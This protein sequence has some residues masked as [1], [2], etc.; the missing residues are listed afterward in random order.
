MDEAQLKILQMIQD[1]IISAAEAEGLL[2]ALD[3]V[4]EPDQ[5]GTEVVA[6]QSAGDDVET[7]GAGPPDW[8]QSVWP[9]V[10]AGGVLLLALGVVFTIQIAQGRSH[11][12]WLAC[13]LPLLLFGAL[14]AG[15]TWWSRTARWLHV[16]VRDEEQRIHISLPLPL[17]LAA[18]ALRLARPWVPQL[19]DSAVDEV[20]LALAEADTAG[21]EML[22]VEVDDEESGE[23]V[24]V[25]IG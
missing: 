17:R 18:W 20:I 13:T 15:L 8:W 14:L 3:G 12:G 2:A 23:Q 1:G 21:G 11:P 16:R 10:L 22:V 6:E 25:R 5:P 19:K 9:Y 4:A 24:E 7:A